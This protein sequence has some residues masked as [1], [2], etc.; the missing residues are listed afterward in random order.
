MSP[1][2]VRH[3]PSWVGPNTALG[4]VNGRSTATVSGPLLL[5]ALPPPDPHAA[6]KSSSPTPT[7][8]S[9]LFGIALCIACTSCVAR[10]PPS[11]RLVRSERLVTLGWPPTVVKRISTPP[12]AGAGQ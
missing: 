5:G 10:A 12:D 4:P 11:K 1:V 3:G 9:R 6:R 7:T 2:A 8:D